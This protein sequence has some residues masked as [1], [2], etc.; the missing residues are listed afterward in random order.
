MAHRAYKPERPAGVFRT[1]IFARSMRAAPRLVAALRRPLLALALMAPLAAWSNGPRPQAQ[2]AFGMSL[3]TGQNGQLF[4]LFVVKVF[5]G[6]VLESTPLTRDQFIRQVQGRT[7]SKA[8]PDAEDLFRKHGVKAC[9]LPED[10]AALGFLT[11]CVT[12]D[13]LWRLRFWEYPLA[14]PDATRMGQ[15]W[16]EKPTT[17]SERQLLLLS[18]Y[19]IR[20]TTDL[21][22]GDNLFNLLRDMGDPEWVDNYRKGY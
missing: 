6:H 21:C 13:E 7:F 2:Y 18:A 15:G 4:T 17:P 3:A 22:Y 1:A 5:E 12:L 8:N 19:G 16:A 20:Y 11:D 14:G 9:T 10:S